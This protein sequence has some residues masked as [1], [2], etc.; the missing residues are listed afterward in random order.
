VGIGLGPFPPQRARPAALGEA[1]VSEAVCRG[2]EPT[3]AWTE[4][5]AGDARVEPPALGEAIWRRID[6]SFQRLNGRLSPSVNPLAQTGAV[7]NATFLVALV[8]G[9]LLLIWYSSSVHTAYSSLEGMP[10]LGQLTR[11][12]HRYSSDAC[13]LFVMLHAFQLLAARRYAGA[14]WLAW[15]SGIVLLGSLWLDGWLGYWL[16]WDDRAAAIALGSAHM[17]DVVPIFA[18]PLSRSF[19]T[20]AGVNS[21][22]FFVVF[23]AHMLVPAGMGAALLVHILR[24]SRSR[25]LPGRALWGWILASLVIVSLVLPARSSA[26][27]QMADLP[28]GYSLDAFYML[29]L[30]LTDRLSG[31]ALWALTLLGVAV[32]TT[33]PWWMVRRRA[34]V[35]AVIEQRCNGC[36]RC[37]T[38]CPYNAIQMVTREDGKPELSV[39]DPGKCVGCGICIGSCNS[40]AVAYPPLE[41]EDV[42]RRLDRWLDG[43]GERIAFVCAQ[44]SGA[45]LV[46]D[47]A[48]GRCPDLPGWRVLPVPCV[49]WVHPLMIERAARHGASTVLLAGC[50]GGDPFYRL[51]GALTGE[52]LEGQREPAL[53][54]ERLGEATVVHQAGGTRADLIRAAAELRPQASRPSRRLGIA[55]A[56][57]L[58]A[59]TLLGG[60]VPY[61]APGAANSQLV[62]SFKHPG[63]LVD[64]APV[65]AD[66]NVPVHMRAQPG[67]GSRTRSP[68]QLRVVVDGQT[69]VDRAYVARGLF[70]DG[71]SVAMEPLPIPPGN[72]RVEV[73]ILDGTSTYS[74]TQEV[75]A[76]PGHRNVVLF[77][78]LEGFRWY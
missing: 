73:R 49:G 55:V 53:R 62:V 12:L 41:A 16:V 35:P 7:A 70:Q 3:P 1:K 72:H 76:R 44:C 52:R 67:Q 71:N 5:R 34:P 18:D 20:D 4:P 38:D 25:F 30:L 27:A 37:A 19:L 21:L 17:L 26:P 15:V 58:V 10:F 45:E 14:R 66:P 50:A 9:A 31:G 39:I 68:V 23:F 22:L 77:D 8:S 36:S 51:G 56:V 61:P 28:A 57:A 69:V 59:V 48:S 78:K 75:T 64:T 13:M 43:S 63:S 11:S 60:L 32:V 42:R 46:V 40:T 74:A 54:R 47:S 29:P 33:V 6:A 24:L 2:A 65:Q